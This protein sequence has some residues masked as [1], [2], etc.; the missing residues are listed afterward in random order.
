[1]DG[2]T[3]AAFLA[4]S[5]G[6]VTA[7]GGVVVQLRRTDPANV[8][9]LQDRVTSAEAES[10]RLRV[11]AERLRSQLLTVVAELHRFKLL[12]AAHGWLPDDEAREVLP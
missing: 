9:V 12:A 3:I 11:E 1:M 6:L 7:V 4:G 5:A 8:K 2:G 10:E